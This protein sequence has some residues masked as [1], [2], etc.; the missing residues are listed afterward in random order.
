MAILKHGQGRDYRGTGIPSEHHDE[1]SPGSPFPVALGSSTK[2]APKKGVS[3][4]GGQAAYGFGYSEGSPGP[5]KGGEYSGSAPDPAT[6]D[7]GQSFA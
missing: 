6:G 5:H 1:T 4:T 7:Q 3:M 2:C